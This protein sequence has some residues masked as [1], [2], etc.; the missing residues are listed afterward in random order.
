MAND[1]TARDGKISIHLRTMVDRE[2]LQR[3]VKSLAVILLK[4]LRVRILY[5]SNLEESVKALL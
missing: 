2:S 3:L 5:F 1:F 4:M